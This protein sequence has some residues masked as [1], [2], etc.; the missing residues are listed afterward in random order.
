MSDTDHQKYKS[1]CFVEIKFDA[2]LVSFVDDQLK[3]A[4]T[5]F[6]DSLDLNIQNIDA[7]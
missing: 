5:P 4:F 3:I 6:R 7:I 2:R 1:C